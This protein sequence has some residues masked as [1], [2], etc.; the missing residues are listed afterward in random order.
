MVKVSSLF[1]PV[2]RGDGSED[3]FD[4]IDNF[5]GVGYLKGWSNEGL[6]NRF[7]FVS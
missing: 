6:A 2:F 1:F 7:A 3:V 4:F 5:R